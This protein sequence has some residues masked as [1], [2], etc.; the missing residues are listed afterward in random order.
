MSLLRSQ[1]Q[2]FSRLL[3]S[4]TKYRSTFSQIKYTARLLIPSR[5]VPI[6]QLHS[7]SRAQTNRQLST[8]PQADYAISVEEKVES[9]QPVRLIT[10]RNKDKRSFQPYNSLA[11]GKLKYDVDDENPMLVIPTS[12]ISDEQSVYSE[13]IGA[14]FPFSSNLPL[15]VIS[16]QIREEYPEFKS[17][18]FHESSSTFYPSIKYSQH[19]KV[20]DVIQKAIK[21]PCGGFFISTDRN[22]L[23]IQ[24]PTLKERTASLENYV[25]TLE[26]RLKP[27]SK[28]KERC[29]SYASNS[30]KKLVAGGMAGLCT[31]FGVMAKLTWWD[32]GW[33]VMEPF[34]YF[35]GVGVGIF[36]YLYFLITKRDYTYESLTKYAVNR[37]QLKLYSKHGFDHEAYRALS[38]QRDDMNKRIERIREEYET[39]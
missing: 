12:A 26:E 25:M 34:T 39:P 24:I 36:G 18:S 35:T 10:P 28:L 4:A 31:Y 9:S 7:L 17:I 14:A 8:T 11:I 37:R 29:D 16:Y 5:V 19:F 30:H 20:K 2:D 6:C 1:H 38:Q 15:S 3:F 33:D 13:K 21:S 22:Q 23:F 32:Y 27:L